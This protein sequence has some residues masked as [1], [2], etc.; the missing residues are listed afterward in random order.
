MRMSDWSSDVCSSDL[1]I[2]HDRG[3]AFFRA[4]SK[5]NKRETGIIDRAIGKQS[6]DVGLIDGRDP[7]QN[8]R[9]Q[10][11]KDNDLLPRGAAWT[12]RVHRDTDEQANSSYLGRCSEKGSDRVGGAFRS[13]DLR[14]G[15]GVV[16]TVRTRR[17]P[18]K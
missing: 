14:V 1:Q 9:G 15:K 4:R 8:D 13:E 6:F 12:Q 10:R 16:S 2:A 3:D 7:A 11:Q 17:S 5:A 18:Y